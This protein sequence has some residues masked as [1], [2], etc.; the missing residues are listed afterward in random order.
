MRRQLGDDY[1]TA[2]RGVYEGRIPGQ[3]DHC[4]YW[5]EKARAL[6]EEKRCR[7]AGL[8]ATQGIRGGANREVL[9]RIKE[10][11]NIFWAESDRPWIL[12]GANVHVSMVGF[13][14]RHETTRRLDGT[15]VG[16]I[17]ANLTDTADTVAAQVL[18][19]NASLSFLGNC[20]GGPF[21]V[22]DE[23]G[24]ALLG[25]GGNPRMAPDSDVIR[26][27]VNTQDLVQ[28][29]AR[30]WIIDSGDLTSAAF[31]DYERPFS[32]VQK[33][34]KPE[35]D[36]N[37]NKWL[38]ENWWR[39]QRMRPEMQHAVAPLPRFLVTP[40]TAKHR[41]FLWLA[42]PTLSPPRTARRGLCGQAEEAHAHQPLQR[43]AGLA[44]SGASQTGSGCGSGLWLARSTGSGRAHR[45]HG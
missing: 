11:G 45:P 2:L 7:R 28:A 16:T 29:C 19:C 17:N 13:D 5:F 41:L 34:V 36:A 10:T 33:R 27:V 43:A 6:I 3:A 15:P 1:V 44:R 4:C 12:A 26:P 8:L 22:P 14:D 18:F 31:A 35:R 24:I 32:L 42:S 40:T 39:P 25:A 23:E 38:R 37:R 20:K 30:R 21:D 9:K